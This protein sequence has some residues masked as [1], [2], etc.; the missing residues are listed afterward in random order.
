MNKKELED[1][2]FMAEECGKLAEQTL[3]KN[4]TNGPQFR[5]DDGDGEKYCTLIPMTPGD[6][7]KVLCPYAGDMASNGFTAGLGL[8][9][10]CEYKSKK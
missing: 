6:Q 4:N 5:N 8:Y 3:D 1:L 2:K 10:K 7:L 9:Y